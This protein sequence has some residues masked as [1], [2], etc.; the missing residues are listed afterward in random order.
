M[1]F[2][3]DTLKQGIAELGLN[4]PHQAP[5]Q[6]LAYLKLLDKWNHK[7]NLTAVRHPQDMLTKHVLDSL[8][9]LPYVTGERL[10]DVG[11]GAGLPGL[12]LAIA[13]PDMQFTLLDSHARKMRFVTQAAIELGL[14]HVETRSM[15][16]E[17][18]QPDVLF[19]GVI[20]RAYTSL[21]G[22]Y[23][24]TRRFLKPDGQILAMK[25]AVPE[26]ER[27]NL[28]QTGVK[29]HVYRLNVPGLEAERH[30]VVIC[31]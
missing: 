30:L 19:D 20:S 24:Q 31:L 13:R 3:T 5:E 14:K 23:Q 7:H 10:L 9:V 2:L 15:R 18:Y 16:I 8:A 4:L 11:T 27:E 28:A 21:D 29:I 25:G 17:H 1:N 22:F 26:Q 12:M 6:I